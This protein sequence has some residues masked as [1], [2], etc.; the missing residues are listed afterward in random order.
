M[1]QFPVGSAKYSCL[2]PNICRPKTRTKAKPKPKPVATNL[3]TLSRSH[4]KPRPNPSPQ[5]NANGP[6]PLPNLLNLPTRPGPHPLGPDNIQRL[7]SPNNLIPPI[8]LHLH[9]TP[10][11]Q[12]ANSRPDTPL[13]TQNPVLQTLLRRTFKEFGQIGGREF[14]HEGDVCTGDGLVDQ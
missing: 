4:S 11:L 5:P 7:P 1:I 14:G 8:Q 2:C 10:N 13:P 3:Q 12:R 6:P 9:R